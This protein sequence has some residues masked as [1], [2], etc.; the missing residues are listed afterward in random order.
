M[1]KVVLVIILVAICVFLSIRAG[2]ACDAIEDYNR[3]V[4]AYNAI[5]VDYNE[6]AYNS[7]VDNIAG[8]PAEIGYL[9]VE[10][11]S[12][13]E[14]LKVIMGK[15]TIKKIEKDTNTVYQLIEQTRVSS[16]IIKQIKNPSE[17]WVKSRLDTVDGI[18]GTQAVT[19]EN[20]PDGLL[21]KEGGYN[22]CI[23]FSYRGIGHSSNIVSTGT[24]GGGAVEVYGTFEE[25]K[26]RCEYL[27][28]FDG[29]V[30]YSGS[31]AIV[32][33]MVIRTSYKLSNEE[34][35]E[36]TDAI[37][38]VL[39]AVSPRIC[40]HCGF[41][42]YGVGDSN[43][44]R[45]CCEMLPP[46]KDDDRNDNN[47]TNNNQ[48]NNNQTNNNQTDNDQVDGDESNGDEYCD[49]YLRVSTVDAT[50][51]TNGKK[52]TSCLFCEYSKTEIIPVLG[53]DIEGGYCYRCDRQIYEPS[54][55]IIADADIY[56]F[57]DEYGIAYE[58]RFYLFDGNDEPVA[59][60]VFVDVAVVDD[61]DQSVHVGTLE[62]G[63]DD[64]YNEDG[65][66]YVTFIIC[67]WE[68][69]LEEIEIEQFHI[70]IYD[71]NYDIYESIIVDV[72]DIIDVSVD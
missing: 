54:Q 57:E 8:V 29:T 27:A 17:E 25:A 35:I 14:G 62:F 2:Y 1:G 47:Q 63:E 43:E 67:D 32:G 4:E 60:D 59:K 9:R 52:T 39:T 30:L 68:I 23:Y 55:E 10:N 33:T 20:N 40:S 26:E 16:D 64:Y 21:G 7:G 71:S 18:I 44:C 45:R 31:Y 69:G 70:N 58:I 15:N 37:T 72:R 66:P 12:F 34:Q 38:Q 5:V 53:H 49:H 11:E 46:L 61:Y 24:D 13:W 22:A 65:F 3:A 51:T 41:E 48:T 56:K 36:L 42:N 19:K 6:T 50:C 28:G